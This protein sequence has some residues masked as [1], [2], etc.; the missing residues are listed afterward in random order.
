MVISSRGVAGMPVRRSARITTSGHVQQ[1]LT[2][3]AI[4][5]I[6]S[7]SYRASRVALQ[8]LVTLQT[9]H[10][11][12]EERTTEKNDVGFNLCHARE[13]TRL[14]HATVLSGRAI[15][16]T[17]DIACSYSVQLQ[18]APCSV[19]ARMHNAYLKDVG[20]GNDS[21]DEEFYPG[22]KNCMDTPTSPVA[23]APAPAP[24][25]GP[26]EPTLPVFSWGSNG[27]EKECYFWRRVRDLG[28]TVTAERI[29][30]SGILLGDKDLIRAR[31]AT[32][33]DE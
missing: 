7:R 30:S 27:F 16:R 21:D 15:Q 1:V 32:I 4:V 20:A 19:H 6:C 17:I 23:P 11:V 26:R 22:D 10:K 31:L 8:Y 14:A 9:S 13:G 5:K 33:C 12:D 24:V 2:S 29:A 3:D 18:R 25:A 28:D